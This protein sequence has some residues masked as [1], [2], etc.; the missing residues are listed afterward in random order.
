MTTYILT[1]ASI[2]LGFGA[3]VWLVMILLMRKLRENESMKYEFITIVTHKFRT[4]LTQI[5][6]TT[7]NLLGGEQDS[8]KKQAL[9]DIA[10]SNENLIK[11]TNTLVGLT[12][13]VKTARSQYNFER[14]NLCQLT[15]AAVEGAKTAFHEK[16][17][18][19]SMTCAVS[20]AYILAEKSRIEFV[21]GSLLENAC[22]Y[23]PPGRNIVVTVTANR[24]KVAVSIKDDGI[25][26]APGD[27]PHIT[28]KFFRTKQAQN[29]DTEGFGVGLFLSNSIVKRHRGKLFVNSEG[30]DKGS[31]FNIVFPRV[32]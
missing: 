2:A 32:K 19:I 7:E 10:R 3:I 9:S 4:P 17:L 30:L 24:R 16:N 28:T 6:W 8:Y 5:K 26:I 12:D 20:E 1:I 31:T 23:T 13:T 11:L 22:T 21:L 18:F 14:L 15:E 25:G 29:M 27:I